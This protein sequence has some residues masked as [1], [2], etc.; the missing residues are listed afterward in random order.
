MQCVSEKGSLKEKEI[1]YVMI[2]CENG[3]E[4]EVMER[5]GTIEGIK[6]IEYT[7]GSYDIV[8]KIESS[9]V[10]ALREII[11]LKIRRLDKIRATTTLMCTVSHCRF[12][13]TIIS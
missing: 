5:L 12:S 6:E 10:E 9:S 1:A 2:N 4:S 7:Y 8:V 3:S 13:N 11:S